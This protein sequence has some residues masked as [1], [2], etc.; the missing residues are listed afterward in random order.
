MPATVKVNW[1]E[2]VPEELGQGAPIPSRHPVSN[3][4]EPEGALIDV[5]VWKA[6]S[7]FVHTTVLFFP[8]TTE[9]VRGLYP[10]KVVLPEV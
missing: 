7:L 3:P 6:V 4:E 2:L 9:T 1:Y 5:A 8:I 10:Y